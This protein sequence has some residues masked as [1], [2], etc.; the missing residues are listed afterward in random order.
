VLVLEVDESDMRTIL[1][2]WYQHT[3]SDLSNRRLFDPESKRFVTPFLG[4]INERSRVL[5]NSIS[6]MG[7]EQSEQVPSDDDQ[8]RVIRNRSDSWL[9]SSILCLACCESSICM[10]FLQHVLH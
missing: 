4:C 5:P 6:P 9:C 2:L 8:A 7:H 1:S 3:G 10:Q